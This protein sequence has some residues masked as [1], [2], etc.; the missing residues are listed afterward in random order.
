MGGGSQTFDKYAQSQALH[1]NVRGVIAAGLDP[2]TLSQYQMFSNL[3]TRLTTDK[4]EEAYKGGLR[5]ASDILLNSNLDA[6]AVRVAL[7]NDN[8]R[9]LMPNIALSIWGAEALPKNLVNSIRGMTVAEAADWARGE[10]D[11]LEREAERNV[12]M[13]I[14]ARY[15]G[16]VED[17]RRQTLGI[18]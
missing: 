4:K 11:K 6:D 9:Q 2:T 15:R 7:T 16:M 3:L 14:P 8:V 10:R 13:D 5:L 17:T 12:S 18:N 1:Q